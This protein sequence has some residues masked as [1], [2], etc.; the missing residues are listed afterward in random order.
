[1]SFQSCCCLCDSYILKIDIN[2]NLTIVVS[3]DPCSGAGAVY[4]ARKGCAAT[5]SYPSDYPNN[6]NCKYQLVVPEGYVSR[7]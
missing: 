6:K 5:P 4:V 1:M 3:G 2:L 7:I